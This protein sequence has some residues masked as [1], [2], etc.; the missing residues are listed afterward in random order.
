MKKSLLLLA[1]LGILSSN[2]NAQRISL[3]KTADAVET[4]KAEK[5]ELQQ[6][7][8]EIETKFNQLT[9]AVDSLKNTG[10]KLVVPTTVEEANS[11]LVY[12]LGFV[13]FV[14]VGLFRGKL[15]KWL[16]PFI[17][18]VL[19][20][21]VVSVLGY[22]LSKGEFSINEAVTFFLAVAGG[23]NIIHQIKKPAKTPA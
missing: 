6:K 19:S 15:P 20:S 7:V 21:L 23:S 9:G 17:L 4:L 2:L 14:F 11:V 16:T 13:N 22:F 5:S 8:A 1:L 3:T 18:S 10:G 12:V